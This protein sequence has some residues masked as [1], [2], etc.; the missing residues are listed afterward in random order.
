MRD[1]LKRM[2]MPAALVLAALLAAGCEPA[3]LTL[4]GLVEG[5]PGAELS[6]WMPAVMSLEGERACT[7]GFVEDYEAFQRHL[8]YGTR[9]GDRYRVD[10]PAEWASGFLVFY[11]DID[12]DGRFTPAGTDMLVWAHANQTDLAELARAGELPPV[13]L[14]PFTRLSVALDLPPGMPSAGFG[15]AASAEFGGSAGVAEVRI[16]VRV[17]GTRLV[18]AAGYTHDAEAAGPCWGRV[19]VTRPGYGDTLELWFSSVDRPGHIA[20]ALSPAGGNRP[21]LAIRVAGLRPGAW[22]ML[23]GSGR[24]HDGLVE[25]AARV[26]GDGIARL[27]GLY[28]PASYWLYADRTGDGYS[29]DDR[30]GYYDEGGLSSMEPERP[31]ILT[32]DAELAVELPAEAPGDSGSL[33][34]VRGLLALPADATAPWDDPAWVFTYSFNLMSDGPG[35]FPYMNRVGFPLPGALEGPGERRFVAGM[36]TGAYGLTIQARL[37]TPGTP[38]EEWP[39]VWWYGPE[40]VSEGDLGTL[41]ADR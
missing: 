17:E 20:G 29:P 34:D 39:R 23:V 19:T 3:E 36:P 38:E 1:F 33:M 30:C 31:V 28:G 10:F 18:G 25:G 8:R 41:A 35:L 12:G 4:T 15:P 5:P 37:E 9:E 32:G 16:P 27:P 2:P 22:I 6:G 26:D 11:A 40:R 14:R 24:A 13:R 21:E 7:G